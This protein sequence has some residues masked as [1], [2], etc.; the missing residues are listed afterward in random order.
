MPLILR[1][2]SLLTRAARAGSALYKRERDLPRLLPGLIANRGHKMMMAAIAAAE[3]GCELDRKDGAATYSV[4]RH[5]GL[6][7]ALFAE[8]KPARG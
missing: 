1:R 5:I 6:L 4:H 8:S 7:A 2:P 3:E